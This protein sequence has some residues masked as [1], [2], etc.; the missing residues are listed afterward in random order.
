MKIYSLWHHW[1]I[2]P[3]QNMEAMFESKTSGKKGTLSSGHVCHHRSLPEYFLMEVIHGTIF[4]DG[5]KKVVHWFWICWI[6]LA[7]LQLFDLLETK[8]CTISS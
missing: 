1:H 6:I 2:F 5:S 8:S 3:D 4:P 7:I